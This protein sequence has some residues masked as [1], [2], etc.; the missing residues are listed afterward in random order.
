MEWRDV[1]GTVAKVA[2]VLGAVL[3]GPVGAVAG[4]AGSLL[5]SF[6]GVKAEPEAVAEALRDPQTAL[7]MRELEQER[8]TQLLQWQATQLEAELAN[9]RDARAREVSLAALGHGGAWVTGA[10]ALVV[11]AGFFWMLHA[12]V[13]MQT[14]NEP[15]LLLLGSLGTAFGAVVNYYLGSSLGSYRKDGLA[16]LGGQSGD[17]AGTYRKPGGGNGAL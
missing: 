12:V 13:S 2:P 10:V 4:A 17:R 11:I 1:A 9:V 3:G 7:R 8:M 16:S 6:L 15:A 14:V 5:G